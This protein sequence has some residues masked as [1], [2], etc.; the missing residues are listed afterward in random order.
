MT[1]AGNASDDE[2]APGAAA[3]AA[4]LQCKV[5]EQK[6]TEDGLVD[7]ECGADVPDGHAGLCG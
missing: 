4:P 7:A 6:E 5:K 3:A 1:Y 2:A